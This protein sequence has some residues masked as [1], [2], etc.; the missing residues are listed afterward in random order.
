MNIII[1]LL[2]IVLILVLVYLNK[3]IR[4]E[5]FEDSTKINPVVELAKE[6]TKLEATKKENEFV[7]KDTEKLKTKI[8]E[9]ERKITELDSAIKDKTSIKL[10]LENDIAKIDKQKA[11]TAAVATIVKTSI[12]KTLQKEDELKKKEEDLR[13]KEAESKELA[14]IKDNQQLA[15]ILNKLDE[16]KK[17]TDDISKGLDKDKEFCDTTKEM[18]KAVFKT[19]AP[20]EKDL[21]Y[22]WCMCNDDNKKTKDCDNYL[23]CKD[24]YDKNKDAKNL[25]GAQLEK[26]FSCISTFP[27]FPKYLTTGK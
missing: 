7:K 15:T 16:V 13:K 4:I 9:L 17:K 27:D 25:E 6:A 8:N 21:S 18:P 1:I 2:V 5:N 3:I 23:S 10:N 26:Y 11:L 12:D 24:N 19:Y 20:N 14:K 22:T